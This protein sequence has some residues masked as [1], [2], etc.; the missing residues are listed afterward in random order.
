MGKQA[1]VVEPPAFNPLIKDAFLFAGDF[2]W[3]FYFCLIGFCA[4][5]ARA[6]LTATPK[7]NFFHGAALMVITSYGGSTL[8]AIMVAQPVAFVLNEALVSIC[9]AVWTVM[10]LVP[11]PTISFLKDS[12][13]GRL[14]GS[15][16]YEIMRCH[17]AMNCSA[18]AATVLSAKLQR[19]AIIGPL[20]AGTLGG[21][22]GGFMPLNKGLDP[23]ADGTN[24]RI[25][26]AA[27]NSA[28]LFLS[29]Q[30]APTKDLLGLPAD[31]A[32]FCSVCFF[33]VV[34]LIQSATGY[35]PFGAN[36]LA[37]PAAAGD[38]KKR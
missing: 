3:M 28:W 31:W 32:R 14:L 8:A 18:M 37:A 2:K 29:M 12:S 25:G 38:K 13:V 9:L 5:N 10:Y 15:A 11:K 7:I 22:G 24:W 19:P 6:V 35:N 20:I 30:Y 26:S 16:C 27:V 33:V 4:C 36:P 34:P 23:L 1:V 17:V 21:C